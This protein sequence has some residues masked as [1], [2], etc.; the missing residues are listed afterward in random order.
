MTIAFGAVLFALL[1]LIHALHGGRERD[2]CKT[3]L[4]AGNF[5]IGY[6][7]IEAFSVSPAFVN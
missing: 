1:E 6:R 4:R 3:I 5:F 7:L 2:L